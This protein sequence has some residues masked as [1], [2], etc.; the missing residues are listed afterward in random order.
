MHRIFIRRSSNYASVYRSSIEHTEKFWSEQANKILWFK[1]WN[2]VYDKTNLIRPHWFQG[3]QLN[4]AYNCLDR[5]I[6]KH[7]NQTAIIHDSAMTGKINHI[8]YKQLLQQVKT[9]ANVLSKKYQVKKGDVV[10]IYMP[11]IPQAIVAML[12][13]ARIG[14]IH[15]LVFGGFSAN[16][17]AIR[18]KHSQ[19]KVI[20]SGEKK[21]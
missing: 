3:G 8:T 18:I 21:V 19:P 16:E 1:K 15:N 13:C 10:L 4:M 20:I 9:L 17:L 2:I 14:A 12:A 6:Q 11:M 5:H 7:A